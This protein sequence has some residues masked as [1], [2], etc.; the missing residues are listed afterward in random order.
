M[1]PSAPRRAARRRS[2]RP[3]TSA[4]G[5]ARD[6]GRDEGLMT[7]GSRDGGSPCSTC[8]AA[9]L[10]VDP[11]ACW[12]TTSRRKTTTKRRKT[13]T[14]RRK[15]TT[16]RK[17]TTTRRRITTKAGLTGV[18]VNQGP[19]WSTLPQSWCYEVLL[20]RTDAQNN[21]YCEANAPGTGC[22]FRPPS[23]RSFN[24]LTTASSWWLIPPALYLPPNM[25][26]PEGRTEDWAVLAYYDTHRD[27]CA[28]HC[29]MWPKAAILHN[30]PGEGC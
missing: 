5:L 2:A 18:L 4:R 17:K 26:R 25:G 29:P 30:G 22:N 23:H 1:A 27:S 16:R 28:P 3:A 8:L 7:S 10:P 15:T 11:A 13:T 20:V 12:A 14:K 6:V 24:P 21:L 19:L 9:S